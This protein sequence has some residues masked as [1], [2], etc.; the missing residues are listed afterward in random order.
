MEYLRKTDFAMAEECFCDITREDCKALAIELL[1]L[2]NNNALIKNTIHSL[3]HSGFRNIQIIFDDQTPPMIKIE[4][5]TIFLIRKF[6]IND[7]SI[8][9]ITDIIDN[10]VESTCYSPDFEESSTDCVEHLIITAEQRP[11]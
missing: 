7:K 3:Q 6:K 1:T 8:V 5:K 4:G 11:W 9:E 10:V 2:P